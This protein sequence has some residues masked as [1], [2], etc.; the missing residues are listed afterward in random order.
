MSDGIKFFY[1][2]CVVGIEFNEKIIKENFFGF[3]MFVIVLN[4]YIGYEN[5]VKIV[6]FV[7][8]EGLMLKEVVV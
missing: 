2:Y 3:L 1:D 7:Y 4:F 5:V 8:K 6:K